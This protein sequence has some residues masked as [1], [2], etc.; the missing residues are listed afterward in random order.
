[1]QQDCHRRQLLRCVRQE[2][3]PA[4]GQLAMGTH[5]RHTVHPRNEETNANGTHPQGRLPLRAEPPPPLPDPPPA[6][7]Y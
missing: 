6:H 2:S 5:N 4:A 1:M 7:T 3:S